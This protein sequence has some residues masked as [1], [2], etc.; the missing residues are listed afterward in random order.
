MR[1]FFSSFHSLFTH[2]AKQKHT[3]KKR[4][5][6]QNQIFYIQDKTLFG[7]SGVWY[8]LVSSCLKR[9]CGTLRA[10]RFF[11]SKDLTQKS[12]YILCLCD[13]EWHTLSHIFFL[14]LHRFVPSISVYAE[15][16]ISYV[17]NKLW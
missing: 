8:L 13:T 17:V 9:L 2:A 1:S 7:I 3:H 5:T 14:H 16:K 12:Q 11:I 15:E 4:T 6:S 10:S